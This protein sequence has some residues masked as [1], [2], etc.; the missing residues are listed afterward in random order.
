MRNDYSS[1]LRPHSIPL[2]AMK[3]QVCAKNPTMPSFLCLKK[4][5]SIYFFIRQTLHT[6]LCTNMC[7]SWIWI[8]L[9]KA[10]CRIVDD[11]MVWC[12][13]CTWLW[14]THAAHRNTQVQ[15]WRHTKTS[16]FLF[17]TLTRIACAHLC[18][19]C[20]S[21]CACSQVLCAQLQNESNGI[22]SL[23]ISSEGKCL[24]GSQRQGYSEKICYLLALVS[25]A[26]LSY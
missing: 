19:L 23:F 11:C 26:I 6:N 15:V 8:K 7:T 2:R 4:N 1:K 13:S 9:C 24:R 20:V 17:G 10:V 5:V 16:R 21:V 22:E 14:N 25:S 18:I 3:K 12:T